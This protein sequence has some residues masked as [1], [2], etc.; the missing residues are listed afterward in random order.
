VAITAATLQSGF[1]GFLNPTQSAPVFD[2]ARKTSVVQQLATQIPLGV[3]GQAIP[4]TSTKPTASWVA[5]GAAKPATSGAMA[6]ET[7]SPKKLTAIIV[8]SAEVARANPGDFANR[9]RDDLAE[10]FAVAFDAAALHGTSTPFAH[11][12]DETT[13]TREIGTAAA[14]A[15]SVFADINAGLKLLVDDGKRMTGTAWDVR[16]EPVINAAVDTTGRPLF[17]DSPLVD[18]NPSVRPGRLLGRP[19]Y[20]GET[21]YGSGDVTIGYGGDWSQCAWGVVG[22]IT[23]SVDNKAAVTINGSLVSMFENNLVAVLAEAEYGFVC[24]DTAAFVQFLNAA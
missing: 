12:I 2:K 18:T 8:M 11:Y 6:L 7:M 9:V 17:I 15:G 23:Y 24:H 14:S 4:Y 3:T 19:A 10:A 13:K 1:S 22:G 16:A 20:I 21:V 5:E